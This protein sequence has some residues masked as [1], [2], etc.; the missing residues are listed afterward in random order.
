MSLLPSLLSRFSAIAARFTDKRSGKGRALYSMADI[1][2][3]A[4]S[5]FF[6]QC[7]SFLSFQR[8]L[9]Q[10]H[11][12]T[13]SQTL[14]GMERTPS[15]NH[16]RD[17]LDAVA[18]SELQPCFDASLAALRDHGGLH[19]FMVLGDRTLI[20]LDGTE[21][22]TSYQL[23]CPACQ[24]RKRSNGKTEHYHSMLCATLVA[25]GHNRAFPLMPEFITPQ[26][27][28]DKQDC[29]LAAGK[30]W[31]ST[32]HEGVRDLKP[33][34]L[35]DALFACQPFC[36][37]IRDLD[38]DFLFNSKPDKNKSLY[39]LVDG[40]QKERLQIKTQAPRR[41]PVTTIYE[42]ITDVPLRQADDALRVNWAR[43]SIIDHTGKQTYRNDIV[44]NLPVSKNTIQALLTCARAR[45]KIENE[46]FNVLKN[47]G[48][49]IEHNFGHG[50]E[51]LAMVFA[52]INLLAFACHT[53]M[54]CCSK[55]WQAVRKYEGTRQHFF[56]ALSHACRY[57]VF[58][59]WESLWD[60][61]LDKEKTPDQ[62]PFQKI[63]AA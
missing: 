30:R 47:N 60:T 49:H 24:T 38:A 41:K 52:A 12:K 55:T 35:G 14:F 18:P 34:Y 33:I 62:T 3:G 21:Y 5:L 15:D 31:L 56:G 19:D 6:M 44:T 46:S 26:D 50:K 32:Q 53:V 4:F 45:W 57:L 17:M 11:T 1:F 7:P 22:F 37:A 54:D 10:G 59:S 61:M 48:Y 43:M 51:N 2:Q 25:P 23:N 42:W 58:P 27:G 16:I 9:E 40:M 28:H 29:E 63:T 39:Q 8:S 36:A 20:A 13:N